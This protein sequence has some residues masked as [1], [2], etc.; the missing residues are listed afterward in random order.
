MSVKE[1]N[2]I[3]GIGIDK[4]TNTLVFLIQIRS[5]GW[6]RNMIISRLSKRK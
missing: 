6:F 1:E 3:D 2:V 5:L 4:D